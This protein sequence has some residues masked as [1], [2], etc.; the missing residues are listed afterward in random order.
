MRRKRLHLLLFYHMRSAS[1]ISAPNPLVA[2]A[3]RQRAV[4]EYNVRVRGLSEDASRV[5]IGFLK[6]LLGWR[7]SEDASRVLGGFL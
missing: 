4:S 5:T 1:T 7:L 6:M 2:C 3:N